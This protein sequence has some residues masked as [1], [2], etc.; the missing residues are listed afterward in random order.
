MQIS[1]D[2]SV[3]V[4]AHLLPFNIHQNTHGAMLSNKCLRYPHGMVVA[5]APMRTI[6]HYM[7]A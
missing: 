7:G 2:I 4:F 5:T 1:D 6:V 3:V